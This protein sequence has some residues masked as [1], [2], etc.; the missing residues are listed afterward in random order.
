MK[1]RKDKGGMG[2]RDLITVN[3][4]VLGKQA[5]RLAKNLDALSR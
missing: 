5:W 4:A 2:F 3:K 1:T